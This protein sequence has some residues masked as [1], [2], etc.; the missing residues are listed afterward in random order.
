MKVHVCN[1]RGCRKIIPIKE[2]YCVTHAKLHQ[3][4]QGVTKEERHRYYREYNQHTRDQQANDFYHS[5][6]WTKVRN[7]VVNRDI[8]TSAIT[9]KVIPDGDLIV[10]HIVRRDVY[11]GDPLDTDNLWCLS[12]SEHA[13]KTRLEESIMKQPKG[14]NKLK[15]IN[16]EWWIKAIKERTDT[17]N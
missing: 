11:K 14:T 5:K 6:Q 16:R 2:R 8:Y 13:I 12:R 1:Q 4:Y 3:P 9:G 7:Y 10:D 15:H 17:H